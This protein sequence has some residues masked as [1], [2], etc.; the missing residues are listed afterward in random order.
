MRPGKPTPDTPCASLPWFDACYPARGRTRS[1]A[2]SHTLPHA[3]RFNA[4]QEGNFRL[5]RDVGDHLQRHRVLQRWRTTIWR[6]CELYNQSGFRRAIVPGPHRRAG[7]PRRRSPR[8]RGQYRLTP[9][10]VAAHL[11]R[12][13]RTRTRCRTSN[14]MLDELGLAGESQP[15]RAHLAERQT[16]GE[17]L[18][19]VGESGCGHVPGPHRRAGQPRRDPRGGRGIA[20]GRL[21]PAPSALPAHPCAP[22]PI[23]S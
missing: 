14:C 20:P 21:P 23:D 17:T 4:E 18:A 11:V 2:S 19:L 3:P 6:W 16:V 15:H 13:T 7:Q 9:T 1:H 22:S 5:H 8:A 12:P 10:P